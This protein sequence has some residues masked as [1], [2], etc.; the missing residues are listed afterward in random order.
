M[1]ATD[2]LQKNMEAEV[3]FVSLPVGTLGTSAYG[4]TALVFI[5]V[6]GPM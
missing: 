4:G 6:L 2:R 3:R 1:E 5:S